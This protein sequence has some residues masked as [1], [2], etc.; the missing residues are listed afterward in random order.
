L[1][2]AALAADT[3]GADGNSLG[4]SARPREA[5]GGA[6]EDF[7][8]QKTRSARDGVLAEVLRADASRFWTGKDTENHSA[9]T[10]SSKEYFRP[11]ST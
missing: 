4:F 2:S 3:L 1:F 8:R 11:R 5:F 6:R 7:S 10:V 9:L